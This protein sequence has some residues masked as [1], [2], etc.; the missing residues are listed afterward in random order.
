MLRPMSWSVKEIASKLVFQNKKNIW[1]NYHWY[2]LDGHD[3]ETSGELMAKVGPD[4]ARGVDLIDA[5]RKMEQSCNLGHFCVEQLWNGRMN[6]REV[7]EEEDE[8]AEHEKAR[9][10]K[11]CP[12]QA[13][14]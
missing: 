2:F 8:I 11:L 9:W 5:R 12:V 4:P 6:A 10:K 14:G 3:D 1:K 7:E 13:N